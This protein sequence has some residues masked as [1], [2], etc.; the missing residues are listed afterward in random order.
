VKDRQDL[1]EIPEKERGEVNY[2]KDCQGAMIGDQAME[3]RQR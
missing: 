1:E 2:N 3:N